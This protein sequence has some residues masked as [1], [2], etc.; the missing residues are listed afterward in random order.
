MEKVKVLV[1]VDTAEAIKAGKSECGQALVVIDPANLTEDQRQVLASSPNERFG[2]DGKLYLYPQKGGDAPHNL[3]GEASE[4]AVIAV[5][6]KC[7]QYQREQRE[8]EQQ[9]YEANVAWFISSPIES[10]VEAKRTHKVDGREFSGFSN[11]PATH[12]WFRKDSCFSLPYGSSLAPII[13]DPRCKIKVAEIDREIEAH[14]QQA[15]QLV[16]E[17]FKLYDERLRERAERVLAEGLTG[18]L[19]YTASKPAGERWVVT[20]YIGGDTE[21]SWQDWNVA[22]VVALIAEAKSEIKKRNADQVSAYKSQLDNW[23]AAHGSDNQKKRH[24]LGLLPEL[25]I[26]DAIRNAAFSALDGF[27][28]YEKLSKND[29]ECNC[30]NGPTAEFEVYAAESASAEEFD[31]MERITSA[32][33]PFHPTVSVTLRTHEAYCKE[34]YDKDE[35]GEDRDVNNKTVYRKSVLVRIK[36]GEL[37]FSREYQIP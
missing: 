6:D 7:I 33:K 28:R 37:E 21:K 36:V 17:R 16:R 35:D 13:S 20:E 4:S 18:I 19:Q 23:V 25:E 1:E 12:L 2:G 5:I 34:C 24:E 26:I 22:D 8:K 9:Q 29:I 31:S 3:I 14:N 15:V 10:L 30:Y 11:E 32:I 27:P